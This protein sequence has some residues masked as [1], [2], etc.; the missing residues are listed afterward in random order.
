MTEAAVAIARADHASPEAS[1]TTIAAGVD[2][3]SRSRG[4]RSTRRLVAAIL[5]AGTATA[6]LAAQ[7]RE[8]TADTTAQTPAATPADLVVVRTPEPPTIDG[9]LDEATWMD[10]AVFEDF[11]QVEPV[12]GA[13]PSERTEVRLLFDADFLYVGF[14]CFDRE[15]DRI[16][17]KIMRRDANLD[18]DDRVRFVI[19]TFLDRRNG[20][21][22]ELNAVGAKVDA[23][24]ENNNRLR[25]DWDG[26]WYGK[27]SI[28]EEGWVA[29][30]A[31]PYK[32]ISFNPNSDRWGFNAERI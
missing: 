28:D 30:F 23:L 29:E 11:L 25:E 21:L 22:F 19:D 5:T 18:S 13:A 10:A 20:F 32:T 2:R 15:P 14:R 27:A 1:V 6:P 26:I 31:I 16:I 24:V 4:H 7:D 17:G 3:P 8:N 12:E 9:R